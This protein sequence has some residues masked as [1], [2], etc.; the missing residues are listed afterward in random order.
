MGRMNYVDE[1]NGYE[2]ISD[3][4]YKYDLLEGM[5]L[6]GK[7]TSDIVFILLSFDEKLTEKVETEFVGYFYGATFIHTKE[8]RERMAKDIEWYVNKYEEKMNL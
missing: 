2:F 5:C 8:D 6:Q 7:A 3:K 1:K 4:G